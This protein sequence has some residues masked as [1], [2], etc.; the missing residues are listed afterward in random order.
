MYVHPSTLIALGGK[1]WGD[2]DELPCSALL[3]NAKAAA[4][5]ATCEDGELGLK[6]GGL[7]G[8]M[9]GRASRGEIGAVGSWK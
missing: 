5:L 8:V 1:A 6:G 7:V 3:A 2:E 9:G 4:T